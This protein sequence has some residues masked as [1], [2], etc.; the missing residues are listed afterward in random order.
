MGLGLGIAFVLVMFLVVG[1][2]VFQARFA[3]RH[4]RRVIAAGDQDALVELL[5]MTFEACRVRR[6]PRGIAPADWRALH[7]A[8]LIAA[9]HRRARVSLLA[10]PDVQVVGGRRSEV[11]SAQDVARRA[12]VRMVERLLYEVPYVSFD[13]VQV[14]VHTEY[15]R[16]DGSVSSPC[17]LTTRAARDVASYSDWELRDEVAMLAEWQTREASPAA[18][19]DPDRDAL[20]PSPAAEAGEPGER[21]DGDAAV[22]AAEQALRESRP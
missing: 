4:W 3:A 10:E 8:A 12:A 1:F 5:D 18:A 13:E 7:T 20:L 21:G 22:R 11:G 15:R 17:L 16:P 2:M 6:P 9:D 14:D 19:A